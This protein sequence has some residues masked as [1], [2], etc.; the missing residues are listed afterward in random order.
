MDV[1]HYLTSAGIDPFQEWLDGLK[2]LK[3]RTAVLRRVDRMTSGNFGDHKFG[4]DGVWE[5]RLDVGPGYRIYYVLKSKAVVLLLG[6]GTKRTQD[7]DIMGA[8]ES[9]KDY[10]RRSR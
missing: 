2:D 1:S 9:L 10:E 3:A 8:V 4:R 5:M 6:G 7:S